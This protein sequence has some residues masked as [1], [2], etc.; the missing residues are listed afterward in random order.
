MPAFDILAV[1]L[2]ASRKSVLRKTLVTLAEFEFF[3][4][5]VD[6]GLFP[7]DHEAYASGELARM[8]EDAT[9]GPSAFS[10]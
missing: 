8:I 9:I 2:P 1:D 4:G 10:L 7:N 3:S 6:A 5:Y